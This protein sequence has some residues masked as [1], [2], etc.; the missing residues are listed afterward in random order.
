MKGLH[1]HRIPEEKMFPAVGQGALAVEIR[2]GDFEVRDK[3]RKINHGPSEI[4]V[5]AE[6]SFLSVLEGGCQVPV[7]WWPAVR[8]RCRPADECQNCRD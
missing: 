8:V 2:T 5:R 4:C 3:I 1:L 6:R 7:G